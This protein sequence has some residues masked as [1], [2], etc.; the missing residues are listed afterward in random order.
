MTREE[1]PMASRLF[2]ILLGLALIILGM[3]A[4]W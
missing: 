4:L 1:R 3:A 2:Q